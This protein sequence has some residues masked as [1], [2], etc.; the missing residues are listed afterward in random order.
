VLS[1]VIGALVMGLI[2]NAVDSGWMDF[3]IQSKFYS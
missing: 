1:S 3:R 2:F